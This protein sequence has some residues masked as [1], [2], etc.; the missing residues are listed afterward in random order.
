MII[1]NISLNKMLKILL[2]NS[3][4]FKNYI[5]IIFNYNI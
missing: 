1:I 2:K 3:K 4:N 5:P